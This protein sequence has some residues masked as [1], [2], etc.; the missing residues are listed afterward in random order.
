MT[1]DT[2]LLLLQKQFIINLK[3][4][5]SKRSPIQLQDLATCNCASDM[6]YMINT[7]NNFTT[8]DVNL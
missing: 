2:I 3:N 8:G 7:V 6:V 4:L 5:G 1:D